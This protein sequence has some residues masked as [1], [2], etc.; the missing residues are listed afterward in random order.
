LKHISTYSKYCFA[1]LLLICPLFSNAQLFDSISESFTHQPKFFVKFDTRN[2]FITNQYAKIR[3]IKVGLDYNHTT[4]IGLGFHWLSSELTKEIKVAEDEINT[5]SA[6]LRFSYISTSIEYAFYKRPKFEISIPVQ[7]GIGM[8]S[9]RYKNAAGKHIKEY[10]HG[11]FMYEPTMT[12]QYRFL[13]YFG[14][15]A[16]VGY[17]LMI[18]N[19]KAIDEQFTSPIYILRFKV[20]FGEIYRAIFPKEGESS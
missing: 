20:F 7:L 9:Y 8:S 18:V 2:S 13:R 19:N 15:G 14:I 3:G 6:N 16:G 1:L 10:R 11:V 5:Y 4:K 12:M 17:R